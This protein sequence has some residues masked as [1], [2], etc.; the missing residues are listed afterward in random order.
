MK[1]KIG[2]SLISLF[3]I[4][5]TGCGDNS[6]ISDNVESFITVSSNTTSETRVTSSTIVDED[7][8]ANTHLK[9]DD[10]VFN[11]V[12]TN[13]TSASYD[14][15]KADF[16]AIGVERMLTESDYAPN[17]ASSVF[18]NYV[19]GDTTQFT[20]YNGN[21]TVKVRYLAVDTPESTSEIEEWGKS[22]SNFNK[23]ILKAAKH[24]I[25]Q[26]ANSAK[27][28][29]KGAAEIDTY[30]RSLAY[31]W[32]SNV[33]NPTKNDF[34]NLN[35]ELVYQGYSL[36]NGSKDDMDSSF[37]D[38]FMK[39]NDIA[40]GLKRHMFSDET[41]PNYYYGSPKALGLDEL[42][43]ETYYT[44]THPNNTDDNGKNYSTFCD[45]KTRY[46]FEGVVSRKLGT[47]FYIQDKIGDNYYGLYVFTLKNYAPIKIGNRVKISGVLSWYGGNYELTGLS[48]SFFEHK[49]GDIEYVLDDKGNR[50]TEEV[51][52]IKATVKEINSGKY[53]NILCELVDDK[54]DDA[55]VYFNNAFSTYNGVTSSYASGG[56]EEINGYNDTYPFYN[57]DNSMILFGK[58]GSDMTNTEESFS[59]LMSSTSD[60]VRVKIDSNILISDNNDQG[61]TT[62]KYF[63]GTKD[64]D[65]SS[66]KYYY[67][68][69]KH[70][71]IVHAMNN[72]THVYQGSEVPSASNTSDAVSGDVYVKGD[73][74]TVNNTLADVYS[75][76]GTEWKIFNYLTCMDSE[77]KE[78]YDTGSQLQVFRQS[79]TRKKVNRIVGVVANYTSTSGKNSKYSINIAQAN[80]SDESVTYDFDNF[81]EVE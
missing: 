33:D 81:V 3:A 2:F 75:Y 32:Y 46:T 62:Y 65:G 49:E 60:Y 72:A 50:I 15:T 69:P 20:S 38:A 19:D 37:Y 5:L 68:I 7:V 34:R 51:T 70:A 10:D 67:Y 79:Y 26:S 14:A 78:V 36:F 17:S 52:P 74:Y 31:V 8:V 80:G 12:M 9:L 4:L 29:K 48:Y 40:R 71:H 43:D 23:S 11:L 53:K 54:G 57:T 39:A 73:W 76:D 25:V 35:L 64:S 27:T 59:T 13:K 30:N 24:V 42:Y 44:T 66:E 55:P 45:Y 47:A 61:I 77:G 6:S 28:G 63:T 41:D 21:Y 1:R 56:S 16:N 18:T 58:A 22:A